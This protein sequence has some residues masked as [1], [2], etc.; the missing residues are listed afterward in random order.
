MTA[1]VTDMRG[2][3]RLALP[4]RAPPVGRYHGR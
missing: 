3:E 2:A 1:W 4:H